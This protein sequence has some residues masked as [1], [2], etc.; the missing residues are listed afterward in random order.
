MTSPSDRPM[1]ID[2][3]LSSLQ[4]R[5]KELQCLYRVHE[6]VQDRDAPVPRILQAVV[7]ALPSGW[8]YP[9]ACSAR[10]TFEGQEYA[11]AGYKLTPWVQTA[12]IEVQ[13][14]RLGQVEVAYRDEMPRAD[15]G[16][17]LAEERKLI[18]TVA[19]RLGHLAMERRLMAMFDRAAGSAALT[20]VGPES[21]W[22]ILEFLSRTDRSL[23]LRLSRRMINHLCWHDVKEAQD[24]LSR[25]A[26][27]TG[28]GDRSWLDPARPAREGEAMVKMALEAF[29]MASRHVGD[30]EIVACIQQWIK[31]EKAAFLVNALE[32]RDASLSDIAEAVERHRG[33]DV[34]ESE[35]SMAVQKGMRVSLAR[36][37]F[38]D[39]LEFL[40]IAKEH[41][42][43]EDYYDLVGR[44]VL[45]Q[46]SHGKLGGKSAG[47]FL[48]YK[49]LRG[50]TEDPELSRTIRMPRT[51]YVASDA[52]LDFIRYNDLEDVHNWKYMD[53]A[54][55]RQEH[56]HIVQVFKASH[57]PPELVTGLSTC[58]D[59]FENR[60][61]IV[62]SSSLLEDRMGSAFA[63]KYKSLFLANQGSKRERLTALLDAVAEVYA[64]IFHPDPIEYRAER[65]LLD[66]HEEMGVMIQEV[67]G[68]EVGPY[69]L[70][71]F[72]G[73]A[74]SN[75]EFRWSARIKRDDGLLRL[76]PG[77]GTR[78][79][80]RL[81]DDY[82]VLLAPGQPNLRV[83]VGAD[84]VLRY[85][86]KMVDV[87]DTRTNAVETRTFQELN[88]EL[89][90]DYPNLGQVVSAYEQDRV[91]RPI[92]FDPGRSDGHLVVTFEGLIQDTP[93]VARMRSILRILQ[94]RL[95]TPVDIEFAHDG[96]HLY[97]LQCRP[98]SY[99]RQSAPAPIPH[100]IP[101]DR[102][103]FRANRYV[104]NGR[105]PDITHVVYVDPAGY[106]ELP[107]LASL[108]DVGRA[109]SKLNKILPKRQ[110]VLIGPGRWGSRGDI[111]LG[112]NV[113]YSDINNT[114]ML[115]EVARKQ[116]NYVPD[117]SFGTHF[118]QDLVESG[119][120]Y[121]PLYPDDARS[122]FNE[123]FL[124][125]STNLLGRL[126]PEYERLE[127]VL[128]VIDVPQASDGLVMRIPMNADLDEAVAYLA[129][130]AVTAAGA[131]VESEEFTV[132][133]GSEHWRWRLRMAQRIAA[134]V[135]AP[136]FGIKAMYVLGSTKNA[137]AGPQSDI[138]LLVHVQEPA[139]ERDALTAWLSGW[140]RCLEEINY[141]RTGYRTDGL[142]DVHFVT[143]A[144]IAAATSFAAKIGAV[145]DA[146]RPL[147]LGP[148]QG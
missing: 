144:D 72:A 56:P 93:F 103:I 139:R 8:H 71:S 96:Q 5:T 26:P 133:P 31:E 117:L 58:L 3:I 119:I 40:N 84:E 130:P 124:S 122:E 22:V 115:I 91:H 129:Q 110:F 6:L 121:L 73:V 18:N 102:V 74:F 105:V 63:G 41:I 35:L 80:D 28:R 11:T 82:P 2:R 87:I 127:H 24:L 32:D 126:L 44:L 47:L 142:L 135:D 36:R 62:R 42:G 67:V 97:L 120:R 137:N 55:I 12:P 111:R 77:L 7:D 29:K 68:V 85:S 20:T 113:T 83:N 109:V 114:A 43:L 81:V 9:Q 25:V 27:E 21:W 48:A 99:S 65:G 146:A 70:P 16:P 39:N 57:F 78:A 143:D 13:G 148:A 1:P 33:I 107:D 69:F 88:R 131:A 86:P 134:L 79:V 125:R 15:E 50:Q 140:S 64:S 89:G 37:F 53:V 54:R 118:F 104:S 75:N 38:S 19:E 95:G 101:S 116:G 14:S 23:L 45:P 76:V 100:D 106:S 66:V 46:R 92:G 34:K 123:L 141:L 61:L 10:I 90:A 94:Q 112:V 30:D 128:R 147:E 136:R 59:E 49:I 4:E 60:P 98:Q 52:L 138:D 132:A 108:R 145:T 51:W 17:F